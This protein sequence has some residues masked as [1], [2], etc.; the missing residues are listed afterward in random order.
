MYEDHLKAASFPPFSFQEL[1]DI[2]YLGLNYSISAII[3]GAFIEN[4]WIFPLG[5]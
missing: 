2:I 5:K 4:F 3:C 1:I